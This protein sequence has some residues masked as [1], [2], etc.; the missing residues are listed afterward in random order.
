MQASVQLPQFVMLNLTGATGSGLWLLENGIGLT[1]P[2]G[3]IEALLHVSHSSVRGVKGHLLGIIARAPLLV[4]RQELY[5]RSNT[6]SSKSLLRGGG[7]RCN[8]HALGT[9]LSNFPPF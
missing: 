6:G 9:T 5:L 1:M 2:L 7:P 8:G 3:E 4:N